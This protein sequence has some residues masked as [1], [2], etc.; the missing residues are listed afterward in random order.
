[1]NINVY[2]TDKMTGQVPVVQGAYVQPYPQPIGQPIVG[3]ASP[4][5][6][7]SS[8]KCNSTYFFF[9]CNYLSYL[10][11]YGFHYSNKTI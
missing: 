9:L 5:V 1:M 4:V 8:S 3:M 11:K 6:V 10:Q 2:S 7:K